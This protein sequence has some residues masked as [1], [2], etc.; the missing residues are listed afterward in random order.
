VE[1]GEKVAVAVGGVTAVAA[2]VTTVILLRRGPSAVAV[3][4]PSALDPQTV[5]APVGMGVYYVTD[6]HL[7]LYTITADEA[8]CYEGEGWPVIDPTAGDWVAATADA[9]VLSAGAPACTPGAAPGP[10]AGPSPAPTPAPSSPTWS[11]MCNAEGQ[12][13]LTDGS[14]VDPCSVGAECQKNPPTG[15]WSECA[16]G[17]TS[18]W[19]C[20]PDAPGTWYLSGSECVPCPTTPGTQAPSGSGC[21]QPPSCTTY[22]TPFSYACNNLGVTAVTWVDG[23]EATVYDPPVSPCSLNLPGCYGASDPECPCPGG[24]GL[25]ASGRLAA[26]SVQRRSLAG[27]L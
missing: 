5:Y 15:P 14:L 13:I 2:V 24:A 27:V 21:P 7:N 10:A 9:T 4:P 17:V 8:T 12:A 16:G 3:P 26:G 22:A 6:A 18:G 20:D 25:V 1:T 11:R 19:V 23:E